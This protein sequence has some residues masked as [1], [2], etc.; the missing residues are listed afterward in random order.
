MMDDYTPVITDVV[1]NRLGG[2]K[3]T[4]DGELMNI[5]EAL[6]NRH[7]R[8]LK[9]FLDNGGAFTTEPKPPAP[10]TEKDQAEER[11]LNDSL[12]KALIKLWADDKGVEVSVVHKQ[13]K[14]RMK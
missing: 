4:I 12:V 3:A 5:P 10:P 6:S 7:Y 13:L 11:M 2:Y 9:K 1:K 8:W 14:D